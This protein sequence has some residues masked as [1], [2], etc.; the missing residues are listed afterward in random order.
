[1]RRSRCR[2]NQRSLKAQFNASVVSFELWP[3]ESVKEV[4]AAYRSRDQSTRLERAK[5][6]ERWFFFVEVLS[7]SSKRELIDEGV[8]I[9]KDDITKWGPSCSMACRSQRLHSWVGAIMIFFT[10]LRL[11]FAG[12]PRDL[13]MG[14]SSQLG[15]HSA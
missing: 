11:S 5:Q 10:T 15:F 14:P 7:A 2:W 13:A 8:C 9:Q 12:L 6:S 4:L 1:M 3:Q